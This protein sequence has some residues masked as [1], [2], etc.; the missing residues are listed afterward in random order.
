MSMYDCDT[1]GIH[2]FPM[3]V[4]ALGCWPADAAVQPP[5]REKEVDEQIKYLFQRLGIQL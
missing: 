3:V 1:E 2:F 5:H 4:E